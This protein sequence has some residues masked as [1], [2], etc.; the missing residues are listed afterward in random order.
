LVHEVVPDE[1]TAD[2]CA[3]GFKDEQPEYLETLG[4]TAIDGIADDSDVRF[5]FQ[6]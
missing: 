1:R 5:P 6:L 2:L 3:S 4:R